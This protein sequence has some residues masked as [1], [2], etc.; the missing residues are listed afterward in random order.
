MVE[1]C[2][3]W[4]GNG[5]NQAGKA[6]ELPGLRACASASHVLWGPPGECLCETAAMY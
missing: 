2:R 5:G 1:P 4:N 6:A 3:Q